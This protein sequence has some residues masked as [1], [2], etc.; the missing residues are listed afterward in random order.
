MRK[1]QG[2]EGSMP[3]QESWTCNTVVKKLNRISDAEVRD[4]LAELWEILVGS[5]SQLN[6]RSQVPVK[7]QTSG[8]L[9]INRRRRR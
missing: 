1:A 5:N 9:P 4:R 7:I 6:T 8:Y 3:R 2:L